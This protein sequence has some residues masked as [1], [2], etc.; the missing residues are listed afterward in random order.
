[1]PSL[2]APGR[3]GVRIAGDMYQWLLAWQ[4]CIALLR[5]Y[6]L[7]L[8]NPVLAVGVEVDDVGNLD[9]VVL[10]REGPPH[11]YMQ[12]KYAID[13]SSPI[14][15]A[16]LLRHIAAGGPSILRK[17]SEA[18]RRLSNGDAPVDVA[19]V[20]NRAPD[21]SDPLISLRDSRTA[22]LM[23]KAGFQTGASARGAARARW[24]EGT[25]LTQDE[26][27][28]MFSVLR[29]DLARDPAHLQE[30]VS[31]QMLVAGLRHDETA[32]HA[33]ADWIAR[34]VRDGQQTLT[35]PA[36]QQAVETLQLR[37]GPARAVVSIATLKPDPMAGD[38]DH[39][40][41]WVDRF[42]G[43]SAFLKRRPL[44]PATWTD[45]QAEV[46]AVPHRLPPGS[47]AVAITGSLRQATAFLTGSTLRMV[48][49]IDL[50]VDQRGQLWSSAAHY[51]APARPQEA[52]HL[53][54]QGPDLAVA[55]A[56]ATDPT[57]DVLDFL[58]AEALP[59]D[60][61]LVL[62]PAGG[63]QDNAVPTAAAANA[64]AVGLRDAV[65]RASKDSPRIHLFLA[66]PMGL[67]M[68][69]GH[70]WNRLRAT[71]VYE[72]VGSQEGYEA[73]FTVDA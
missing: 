7:R 26:L 40:I 58:H 31:L 39:T 9:D 72:D 3:T 34:Q 1:M 49:G 64:L 47:T 59:V 69:L 67:A 52:E 10:H 44:P 25:G 32:V 29:F 65:R 73:A 27:L 38:A 48:T 60:R 24:A 37:A 57:D 62:R 51:E 22:L 20:T 53:L 54:G 33:G 15:E 14:N 16:Y 36:V 21:P 17:I 12:V 46:E 41:D 42:D 66:G 71:V 28:R 56:V 45:L 8:P 43:Q 68:L 2:P 18:W 19:L 13:S 50:A 35:L 63:A 70:R 4:G 5:D 6:A 11:T 23:P 55:I 30:L 61:L